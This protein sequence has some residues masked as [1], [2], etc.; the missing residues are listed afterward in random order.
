M[1]TADAATCVLM[2]CSR[3]LGTGKK[4]C[5]RY[6]AAEMVPEHMCELCGACAGATAGYF[7]RNRQLQGAQQQLGRLAVIVGLN[8]F[9][10]SSQGLHDRQ[11]RAPGRLGG[12]SPACN[13]RCGRVQAISCRAYQ[14]HYLESSRMFHSRAQLAGR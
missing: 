13:H 10:G 9:L 7:L 3:P 12:G 8:F 14:A 5:P 11:Q 6:T 4:R 2:L 1:M